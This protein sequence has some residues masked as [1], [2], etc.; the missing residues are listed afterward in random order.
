M[1]RNGFWRWA[2]TGQYQGVPLTNFAGWPRVAAVLMAVFDA[3]LS[4]SYHGP[5]QHGPGRPGSRARQPG[6]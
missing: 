6:K 4:S 1:I 5:G 2:H 3:L